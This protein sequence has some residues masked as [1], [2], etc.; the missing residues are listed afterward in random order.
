MG[1]VDL[2]VCALVQHCNH[3]KLLGLCLSSSHD[4]E[5]EEAQR[6]SC[7]CINIIHNHKFVSEGFTVCTAHKP[8]MNKV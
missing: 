4:K 6:M 7:L 2:C 1:K 5:A 8:F 3:L